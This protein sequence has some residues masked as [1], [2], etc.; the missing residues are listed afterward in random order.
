MKHLTIAQ[1]YEIAFR[2]QNNESP[3]SIAKALG[4]H[5]STITRE[6]KRNTSKQ[7]KYDPEIAQKQADKRL[8]SRRRRTALTEQVM[9]QIDQMVI[10]H[11]WSPEQVAG[12]GKLMGY[13]NISH[14]TIYRYI[15]REK[16]KNGKPLH[17]HLR[18]GGRRR[19]KRGAI[20]KRRG[21][22]ARVGIEQRPEIVE[23]KKRFGDFEIDTIIGANKR[24]VI[25]TI[26]DRESGLLIMRKLDTKEAHPLA[27]AAIAAL[28][29][30]KGALHTITA[31]NGSEFAKHQNIAKELGIQFFFAN[32]YHSWERGANENTNGLVR[33]YFPKRTDFKPLK[34][35]DIKRVQ[36]KINNRPRKKLGFLT[37]KEY[38]AKKYYKD[39]TIKKVLRY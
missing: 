25:M 23:Q 4:V 7:G 38:I 32:P 37:P 3:S 28:R 21:I 19:H 26:N 30:V 29:P 15:W 2:R 34:D 6:L 10:E 22:P 12:R 8:L 9:M 36:D 33:Q 5:R 24:S 18:H 14:E 39:N 27:A 1:R 20:Y 16:H 11:Q 31:D 17:K 35:K 13:F